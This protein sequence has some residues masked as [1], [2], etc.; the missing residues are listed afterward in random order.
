MS[1]D[2]DA[3]ESL[4]AGGNWIDKPG[5]YHLVVTAVDE[6]PI[7][8]SKELIAGFKIDFQSLEGTVRDTEGRFTEADKTIDMVFFHPKLTDKNEGLFARQKQAAFFI[9]AGLMTEDQLGKK[10]VKIDLQAARGR[11]VIATLEE[12]T[13]DQGKKFIRL[14]YAD[15]FHIDDPRAA[16]FPKNGKALKLIPAAHRRDPKSFKLS[17]SEDQA[18]K[19]DTQS[20]S[21]ASKEN[22]LDDL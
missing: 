16:S 9:A 12:S 18:Q 13:S 17:V 2:F 5:T 19:K 4:P 15:I 1:F 21:S 22:D 11:H 20:Q 10:G 6:E 8:R 3:P 14:A 7:S